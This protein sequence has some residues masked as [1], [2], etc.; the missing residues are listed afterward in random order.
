MELHFCRLRL[1]FGAEDDM[2]KQ[3]KRTVFRDRIRVIGEAEYIMGYP[4]EDIVRAIS[5]KDLEN[6]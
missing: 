4:T 2:S 1:A 6:K 3:K 5:W